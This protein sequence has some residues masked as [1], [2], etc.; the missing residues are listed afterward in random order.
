[1]LIIDIRS[2]SNKCTLEKLITRDFNGVILIN[3]SLINLTT[4]NN[5]ANAKIEAT[6]KIYNTS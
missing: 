3:K 2:L 6:L 5:I 4:K 1:M